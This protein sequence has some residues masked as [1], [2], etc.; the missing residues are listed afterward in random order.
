[1][2]F[3]KAGLDAEKQLVFIAGNASQK[4]ETLHYDDAGGYRK[5][6]YYP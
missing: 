1:M 6:H 3:E 5:G 4:Y 2:A